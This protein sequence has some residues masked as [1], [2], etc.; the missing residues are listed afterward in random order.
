MKK[1]GT[2]RKGKRGEDKSVRPLTKNL[3]TKKENIGIENRVN[4]K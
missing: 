2:K 4:S 1:E 3:E